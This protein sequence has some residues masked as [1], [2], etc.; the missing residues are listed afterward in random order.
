[1]LFNSWPSCLGRNQSAHIQLPHRGNR[2]FP[3]ALCA[4][5][6]HAFA[7]VALSLGHR[8]FLGEHEDMDLI[9]EAIRKVRAHPDELRQVTV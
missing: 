4:Q 5:A 8:F 3:A 7:N 9:L 6:E 1:M 2:I